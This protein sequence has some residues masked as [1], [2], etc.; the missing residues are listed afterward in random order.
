MPPLLPSLLLVYS[1]Y[2]TYTLYYVKTIR[3]RSDS[4]PIHFNFSVRMMIPYISCIY[5]RLGI[6]NLMVWTK[7]WN[8][9]IVG[10]SVHVIIG[11]AI[12]QSRGLAG[13]SSD[14]SLIGAFASGCGILKGSLRA[15]GV[16]WQNL[17]VR[18]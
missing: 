18:L 11:T 13:L 7:A 16:H 15:L 10:R 3:A 4:L 12:G 6:H 9:A 2:S 17:S 1:T 5:R 8:K 14:S